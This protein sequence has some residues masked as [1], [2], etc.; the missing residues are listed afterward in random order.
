[1]TEHPGNKSHDGVDKYNRGNRAVREDIV[2][3][4][5]L[6]IDEMFDNAVIDPFV[7]TADDDEMRFP[8]KLRRQLLVES[9]SSR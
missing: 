4:G 7:M 8:R 5:N 1:M 3:D 9:V 6:K 2:A